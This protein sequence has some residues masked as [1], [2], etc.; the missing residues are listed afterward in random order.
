M[1][2]PAGII[3]G[4]YV[5]HQ[6]MGHAILTV[7]TNMGDLILESLRRDSVMECNGLPFR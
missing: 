2:F 7:K 4:S 3:D 1:E 6:D 5:D